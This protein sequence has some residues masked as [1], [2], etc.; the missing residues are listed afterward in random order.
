MVS[1]KNSR[2]AFGSLGAA[3]NL[4]CFGR[5][6]KEPYGFDGPAAAKAALQAKVEAVL[7]DGTATASAGT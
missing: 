3:T 4:E 2:T 6:L 1:G 5:R 7:A